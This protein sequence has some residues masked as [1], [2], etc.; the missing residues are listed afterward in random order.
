[1]K[2]LLR[3]TAVTLLFALFSCTPDEYET[4]PKNKTHLDIKNVMA[5]DNDG[6]GDKIPPPPPPPPID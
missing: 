6:P 3:F 5:S 2:N 4:Q 1:M